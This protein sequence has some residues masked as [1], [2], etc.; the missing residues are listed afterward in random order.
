M[1]EISFET[2]SR[3]VIRDSDKNIK[4][5]RNAGELQYSSK[6][7]NNVDLVEIVD[8]TGMSLS[9]GYYR[10]V[11]SFARD[12]EAFGTLVDFE[13]FVKDF[14]RNAS[15]GG[16]GGSVMIISEDLR[17]TTTGEELTTLFPSLKA[18]D[19]VS[20]PNAG[21]FAQNMGAVIGDD[22]WRIDVYTKA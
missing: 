16:G 15:S 13:E 8:A 9:G 20:N 1:I 3:V 19:W 18:G 10:P 6:K 12:G 4:H 22:A 2:N 11:D 14:F 21:V 17:E 5:V 7:V